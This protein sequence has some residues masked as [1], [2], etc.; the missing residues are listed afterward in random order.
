MTSRSSPQHTP[1]KLTLFKSPGNENTNSNSLERPLAE[2]IL[3]ITRV[4]TSQKGA[5]RYDDANELTGDRPSLLSRCPAAA[6]GISQAPRGRSSSSARGA[7]G[8]DGE[9]EEGRGARP[10]A[11][12][13]KSRGLPPTRARPGELQ[14]VS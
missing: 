14:Y 13:R 10:L 8:A 1:G 11:S 12:N 7:K 4:C 3:L 5:I 6:S 9:S 2:V